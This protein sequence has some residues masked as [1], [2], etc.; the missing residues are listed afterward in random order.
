MRTLDN[1]KAILLIRGEAP[2]IDAKYPLERHPKIKLTEDGGAAPYLH[3]PDVS[4][5]QEDLALIFD[6]LDEIEI[7]EL[8]D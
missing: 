3:Q 1:A 5:A 8:E 4:F 6:S 7:I 2:V